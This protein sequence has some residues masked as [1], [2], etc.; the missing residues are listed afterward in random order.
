MMK[1]KKRYVIAWVAGF[2]LLSAGISAISPV[3]GTIRV[4]GKEMAYK[5]AGLENRKAGEPVVVC[6]CGFGSGGG[7]Y[8][9]LLSQ[10]PDT[11]PVFTYDRNGLGDS[12]IDTTLVSDADVVTRLH[13][14]LAALQI[15][16]PYLL[17]GHSLGGPLVRL[18]SALYPDEVAGLMLIDPT[19][20]M[21]TKEEDERVKTLTDSRTGYRELMPAMF[22]DIL[23]DP[24]LPA[25]MR[26][27]TLRVK[28][29]L[30]A[31]FFGEYRSLPPLRNIPTLVLIA[32]NR[33]TE[34]SELELSLKNG[35][36]LK[37]WFAELDWLRIRHFGQLIGENDHSSVILLPRYSHG[38]HHQGPRLVGE[39]VKGLYQSVVSSGNH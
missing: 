3:D 16:P 13:D 30:E 5:S 34:Q 15:E 19:D 4:K 23:A 25:G 20:F 1:S 18:F 24:S 26:Q 39:Y 33:R 37:P 6:E 28:R 8:L 10:L 11:M 29:N 17:V 21:L 35:I 12:V 36:N 32:Y 22:G 7:S 2:C 9:P 27:E 38:I 31:G 14:L